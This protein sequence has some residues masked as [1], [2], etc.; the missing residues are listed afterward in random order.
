[1]PSALTAPWLEF[2]MHAMYRA[3]FLGGFAIV[4]V[5][6]ICRLLPRMSPAVRSWL[7]R[8]VYVKLAL[9]VLWPG[10]IVVPLLPAPAVRI[11]RARLPSAGPADAQESSAS[12]SAMLPVRDLLQA[13]VPLG[14]ASVE[15]ILF[16]AWL[17]GVLVILAQYRRS[18][19]LTRTLVRQSRPIADPRFSQEG[20]AVSIGGRLPRLLS[21]ANVSGPQAVGLLNPVV[22]FPSSFPDQY[23]MPE[24]RMVLAHE[25][26]H[27]RRHDLLWAWLRR[28]VKAV[29]FFHPLV[30]LADGRAAL[31]E[32]VACDEAAVKTETGGIG[33]YASTLVK[34][35]GQSLRGTAYARTSHGLGMSRSYRALASR[36]RALEQ[37]LEMNAGFPCSRRRRATLLACLAAAALLPLGVLSL[38]HHSGIR[39]IDP[40]YPVLGVRVSRGQS[41]VLS[42]KRE[43]L[44]FAGLRFT[45]ISEDSGTARPPVAGEA[46]TLS[47]TSW[48]TA[49]GFAPGVGTS[50]RWLQSLGLRP[51]VDASAYRS[52]VRTAAESCAVMVR[53]DLSAQPGGFSE[54]DAYLEDDHGEA[55]PLILERSEFALPAEEC[56]K[57]WVI[58]PAPITRAKFSLRLKLAGEGTDVALLR[59]SEL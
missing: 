30:W 8:L 51:K 42:V 10:P 59:L 20:A 18:I 39:Q 7:W 45:R 1:M 33:A 26:A 49:S 31:A 47:S 21:H 50:A 48:D 17:S 36:F 12:A 41:H 58:D 13:S 25:L 55:I 27:L 34:I 14:S 15:L 35:T 4:C 40:R 43:V 28:L 16:A 53:F 52:A 6:T 57:C 5:W 56:V 29:L 44:H 38:F 9:L 3:S 46:G 32:E 37:A 54:I 24:V 2:W 11:E 22:L 19:V 23:S